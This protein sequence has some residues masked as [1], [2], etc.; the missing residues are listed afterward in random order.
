MDIPGLGHVTFDADYD[1]YL[2]APLPVPAL[3]GAAC[4]VAVMG[5]DDDEAP[6]DFHAAIDAFLTLDASVLESAALPIFQYYQD[7]K[8]LVGDDQGLVPISGPD[9]IWQHIRPGTEVTVE[10]NDRAGDRQVYVSI[11]CE[12]A[13]EPEHGLQIVLRGGRSVTKVG[14]FDG[15][16]TN[17]DASGRDV[18]ADVVYLAAG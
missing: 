14:P 15:H 10:R 11:E 9:E 1:G 3:G 17:A 8:D 18:L 2:S 6:E 7:V 13:W 16:L 12:C 5:Y 4:S